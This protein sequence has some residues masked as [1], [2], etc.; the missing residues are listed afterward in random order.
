MDFLFKFSNL[1][2]SLSMQD[3]IIPDFFAESDDFMNNV[4]E[5]L[6]LD[7]RWIIMAAKRSGSGWHVDPANTTGWLALVQGAKLWG[8]YPPSVYHIPG[9][10]WGKLSGQPYVW[11]VREGRWQL[12]LR[13]C[14]HSIS[15]LSVVSGI[16]RVTRRF[17]RRINDDQ[18]RFSEATTFDSLFQDAC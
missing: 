18:S 6:R 14:M 5:E 13:I 7:W 2:S 17:R 1:Y 10:R 12:N 15:W 3:Y 9:K 16:Y 11:R 8:M 4:D